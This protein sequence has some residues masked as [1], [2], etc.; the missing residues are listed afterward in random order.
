MFDDKS[1]YKDLPTF[2]VV[3]ARGRTVRAVPAAP[4]KASIERGVHLRK[5]GERLDHLANAYLSDPTG[6]W[7]ICEHNDVVNP[8]ILAEAREIAIPSKG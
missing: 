6:F 2:E 7:R 4:A 8:E 3:D 1:R 5:Q